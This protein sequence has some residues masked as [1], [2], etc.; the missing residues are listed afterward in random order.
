MSMV[1][2]VVIVQYSLLVDY[3]LLLYSHADRNTPF[4]LLI[5]SP[6]KAVLDY[7][8]GVLD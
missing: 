3:M 2:K 6:S 5:S 7:Q 1:Y 4:D 8:K